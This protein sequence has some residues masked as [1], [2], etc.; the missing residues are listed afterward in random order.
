[1]RMSTMLIWGLCAVVRRRTRERR[2][3]VD[4]PFGSGGVRRTAAVVAGTLWELEA[5]LRGGARW[6]SWLQVG[7][8]LG[9]T[10]FPLLRSQVEVVN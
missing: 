5:G 4:S 8:S 10:A 6:E 2:F 9:Q 1:M 3:D 7:C